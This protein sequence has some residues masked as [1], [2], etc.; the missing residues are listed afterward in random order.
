MKLGKTEKK[1]IGKRKRERDTIRRQA[2]GMEV[3]LVQR[4]PYQSH[5]G[6]REQSGVDSHEAGAPGKGVVLGD[7][8]GC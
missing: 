1:K 4:R 8:G 3:G 7:L 5:Q 2:E 6:H